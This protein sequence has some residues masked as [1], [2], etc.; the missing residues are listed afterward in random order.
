MSRK[1]APARTAGLPPLLINVI[2][3]AIRA[4]HH[5]PHSDRVGQGQALI[6]CGHLATLTVPARGVLAPSDPDLFKAIEMIATKH[7]DF[8]EA[9]T[10]F[11]Q[12]MERVD[13]LEERDA[14]AT[15]HTHVVTISDAAYYY[16]GLAFGLTL[17]D[18]GRRW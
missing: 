16:T 8:D 10:A 9:R 2:R 3:S 13:H 5:D 6:A 7:L 15:A 12:S 18:I 14:I 4:E 17:A 11:R 1:A